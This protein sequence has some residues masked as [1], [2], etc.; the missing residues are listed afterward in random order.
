MFM[1]RASYVRWLRHGILRQHAY[2]WQ[3]NPLERLFKAPQAKRMEQ[4]ILQRLDR[5]SSSNPTATDKQLPAAPGAKMLAMT[6]QKQSDMPNVRNGWTLPTIVLD[7]LSNIPEERIRRGPVLALGKTDLSLLYRG[8]WTRIDKQPA[9]AVDVVIKEFYPAARPEYEEEKHSLLMT[10]C[11]PGIRTFHLPAHGYNDTRLWLVFT[12]YITDVEVA[13]E[14]GHRTKKPLTSTVERMRI[15]YDV[16]RSLQALARPSNYQEQ[17]VIRNKHGRQLQYYES[18]TLHRDIKANNVLLVDNW[19]SACTNLRTCCKTM[20]D[21]GCATTKSKSFKSGSKGDMYYM[22]PNAVEDDGRYDPTIDIWRFG[23]LCYEVWTQKPWEKMTE[24]DRERIVF[25]RLTPK[26]SKEAA[27]DYTRKWMGYGPEAAP[28]LLYEIVQVA[29]WQ[30]F[31]VHRPPI[32][33]VV[34]AMRWLLQDALIAEGILPPRASN[35]PK[36]DTDNGHAVIIFLG[37][38]GGFPCPS[39][40]TKWPPLRTPAEYTLAPGGA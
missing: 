5:P 13:M 15:L 17:I 12:N 30:P 14:K 32:N 31:V 18:V 34:A 37:L 27:E 22:P 26:E 39:S 24:M 23:L 25:K 4:A 6:E 19:R 20:D 35:E 33:V 3:L 16:A 8:T 1:H 21:G 40:T 38:T 11:K 28:P 36:W 2:P 10:L 9:A 29:L 7:A